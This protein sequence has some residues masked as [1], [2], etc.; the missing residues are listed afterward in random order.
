[1]INTIGLAGKWFRLGNQCYCLFS[2]HNVCTPMLLPC[3]YR[4][5]HALR[6]LDPQTL[7]R[8]DGFMMSRLWGYLTSCYSQCSVKLIFSCSFLFPYVQGK[9]QEEEEQ[10]KKPRFFLLF[11]FLPLGLLTLSSRIPPSSLIRIRSDIFSTAIATLF[12]LSKIYPWKKIN[13]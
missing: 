11:F 10:E 5:T 4:E 2:S 9:G 8:T 1:M 13:S 6:T 12:S 3:C 7:L